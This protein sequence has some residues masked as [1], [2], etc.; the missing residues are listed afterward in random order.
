MFASAASTNGSNTLAAHALPA[1]QVLDAF[2]TD[3]EWG[4]AAEA[5]LLIVQKPIV[6]A[7]LHPEQY[8]YRASRRAL[9][10]VEAIRHLLD[11][12]YTEAVND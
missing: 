4:L 10:V 12:G 11:S 1:A 3:A 5:A 8:V 6:E 7:D 2:A 9:N